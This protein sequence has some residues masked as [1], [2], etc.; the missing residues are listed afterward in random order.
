MNISEQIKEKTLQL[1]QAL[2]SQ[3]PSMPSLL[4]EIWLTLKANPDQVT[5]LS[6][7]DIGIVVRGLKQQTKTEISTT[8]LKTKGKSLKNI[9]LDDL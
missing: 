7:E 5:L 3:H 8:A 9:S 1:E 4:K 2:L 6:E